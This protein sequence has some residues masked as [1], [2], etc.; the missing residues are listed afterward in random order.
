MKDF[1]NFNS[2]VC[3]VTLR[4]NLLSILIFRC[5]SHDKSFLQ[6]KIESEKFECSLDKIIL[7][8][9][10]NEDY[11]KHLHK[12]ENDQN[13]NQH[14]LVSN[15]SKFFERSLKFLRSHT[16]SFKVHKG[17]HI[18]MQTFGIERNVLKFNQNGDYFGD[19][20]ENNLRSGIG[21][22]K[23]SNYNKHSSFCDTDNINGADQWVEYS[24]DWFND[25]MSGK[26][27]LYFREGHKYIGN[28]LS[29]NMHGIGSIKYG[30]G[31]TYEGNW[32]CGEPDGGGVSTPHNKK[33][34][35]GSKKKK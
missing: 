29:H 4:T 12:K 13:F 33:K 30:N 24:G 19:I 28:F 31:D 2:S 5:V 1:Q 25:E 11:Y 32:I 21:I 35:R 14:V 16:I 18:Y 7:V 15:V 10:N 3:N 22:Q 17:T 6:L 9:V 8:V 20:D 27:T 23:W 26:G 34:K